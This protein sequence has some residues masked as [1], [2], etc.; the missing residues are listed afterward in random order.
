MTS[1]TLSGSTCEMHRSRAKGFVPTSAISAQTYTPTSENNHLPPLKGST[2]ALKQSASESSSGYLTRFAHMAGT[3]LPSLSS[4][5]NNSLLSL[6][7]NSDSLNLSLSS[8]TSHNSSHNFGGHTTA[9]AAASAAAPPPPPSLDTHHA[10]SNSQTS[11]ALVKNGCSNGSSC[12]S[13]TRKP[14]VIA[15]RKPNPNR[16]TKNIATPEFVYKIYLEKLTPYEVQEILC[17]RQIYFIGANAK[18]M[19]GMIGCAN[20]NN[21][22]DNEHGSYIHVMHDHVAY[23]YEMLKVIGKGSF[24][25]VVKAYDHKKQEHCALKIVRNEKRFYRQAEEEVKILSELRRQDE[26]DTMNIIHMFD[27]FRFRNHMCITFELLSINLYELIKKN[28]FQGFSLQLVK[29][30][31]HSLLQCLHALYKNRIIHCDLKPENVLLKQP[32]RSG[33]KVIDFGSSCYEDQRVYTYIQSRFYR[34][35][36]VILGAKYGMPIDMWSLGCILVEL[37]TGYPLLPGEDEADQMARIIE[38]LGMPPP[39]L[40]ENAKRRKLFINSKGYPRYCSFV[41]MSDGSTVLHGGYSKKGKGRGPPGSRDLRYLLKKCDDP[42]FL[43]FIHKCLKWDP[44]Q[45]MT[46]VK[47]LK[48]GWLR[49][50]LPELPEKTND[51][52]PA[53]P[54]AATASPTSTSGLRTSAS[55]SKSTNTK[56]NTLQINNKGKTRSELVFDALFNNTIANALQRYEDGRRRGQPIIL[57]NHQPSVSSHPSLNSVSGDASGGG[58]GGGDGSSSSSSGDQQQHNNG[59]HGSLGP[60]G[61]HGSQGSH[62]SQR[63]YGSHG[64]QESSSSSSSWFRE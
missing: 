4:S 33:I 32:G 30:F 27:A 2:L 40:L 29:K 62:G 34:A 24:G 58:G 41:T 21:G 44:E 45:R 51:T 1:L 47:A 31:A 3:H 12:G 23:R 59:S 22:Y 57:T 64:S 46:P 50:R 20:N 25:Q 28:K 55:G 35:P 13:S 15:T 18:K 38:L 37:V 16:K 52:L 8:H 5:S 9:A 19:P 42:Y 56:S 48:H 49:R 61:T 7:G 39:Q 60:L 6:T 36:E 14:T 26:D 17:Y 54:A 11:T 10:Q 53:L 63:S 43:D